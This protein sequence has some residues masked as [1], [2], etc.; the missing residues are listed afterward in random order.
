MNGQPFRP[1]VAQAARSGLVI[2]C[3]TFAQEAQLWP[4][5]CRSAILDCVERRGI[6]NMPI[7]EYMPNRLASG[8]LCLVGDAT[9]VPTPMIGNGFAESREDAFA[10]PRARG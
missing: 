3:S 8:R 7:A 9:H 4:Q 1:I 6:I 10:C 5:P 2:Q